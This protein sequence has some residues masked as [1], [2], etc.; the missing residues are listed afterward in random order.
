MSFRLRL[1][2]SSAHR[3]RLKRT[4]LIVTEVF[5][6]SRFEHL[7]KLT[8]AIDFSIVDVRQILQR[9]AASQLVDEGVDGDADLLHGVAVT[10]G[11]GLV[12]EGVEVDGDAEG[13]ADFVLAAVA[14]SDA[15]GVVVLGEAVDDAGLADEVVDAVGR[16][17]EA[18]VAAEGEDGDL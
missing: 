11:D 10:D 2:S 5:L 1:A 16:R 17:D 15:L 9:L 8:E 6:I 3:Q 7:E 18:F 12:V 4:L 14:A 13:G